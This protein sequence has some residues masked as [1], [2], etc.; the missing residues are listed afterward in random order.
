MVMRRATA[1]ASSWIVELDTSGR[2]AVMAFVR[3]RL[4]RVLEMDLTDRKIARVQG[5]TSGAEAGKLTA[6]S[7]FVDGF[8]A[9]ARSV[10][11]A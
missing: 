1:L 6:D 4:W 9:G 2:G 5:A 7:T 8:P 10:G 11:K 3:E